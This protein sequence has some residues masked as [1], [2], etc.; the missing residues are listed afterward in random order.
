MP[1]ST[2][3]ITSSGKPPPAS[4]KAQRVAHHPGGHAHRQHGLHPSRTNRNGMAS[5]SSTSETLAQR[6]QAC[7]AAHAEVVEI[8]I[9]EVV[10]ERQRDADGYGGQEEHQVGARLQQPQRIQP[11]DLPQPG[12]ALLR[13]WRCVRQGERIQ[14]EH[15]RRRR[16][17]PERQL[18][19][20]R[21]FPAQPADQH[22]RHDPADAAGHADQRELLLGDC[23]CR[24]ATLL[25]SARSA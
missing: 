4:P 6:L 11:Q 3:P 24:M 20:M 9:G 22:A 12:I 7:R 17:H 10:V 16:R 14:P 2:M 1:C 18:K 13:Q 5:I 21:L 15:Q 25:A 19:P 23:M 8:G